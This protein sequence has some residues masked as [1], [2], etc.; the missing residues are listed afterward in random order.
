[1]RCR[2]ITHAPSATAATA[3]VTVIVWS[4]SPARVPKRSGM[5]AIVRRFSSANGAGYEDVHLSTTRS[6]L[7]T[8]RQ[9]STAAWIS[10]SRA[11]PVETIT[12]TPC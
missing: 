5:S 3:A 1:M 10:G 7:P 8:D 2:S 12:G 4:D 9:A 6:S 11:I